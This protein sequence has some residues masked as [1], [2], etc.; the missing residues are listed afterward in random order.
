L[1]ILRQA[2]QNLKFAEAIHTNWIG[3]SATALLAQSSTPPEAVAEVLVSSSRR[4]LSCG[5]G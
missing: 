1:N 4:W 2:I 5:R 3:Q